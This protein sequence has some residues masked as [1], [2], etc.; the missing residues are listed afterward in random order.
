MK[1]LR[2]DNRLF[3]VL[4][5]LFSVCGAII[6]AQPSGGPYGPIEQT[7]V[8][9]RIAANVYYVSP[10]G[11]P[12]QNGKNLDKPT[13]IEQAFEQ[14][15]SGD[16]IILHGGTY[17]TGNLY[18]NQKVTIQ[19]FANEKPVL[20]GTYI[21][22]DWRKLREDIWVTKWEHLFDTV[23]AGWWQKHREGM[24]T[25]LHKF[26]NDM[27]FVNGK[28]MQSCG[29][30]GEVDE[31]HFYIDYEAGEV[32]IGTDPTDKLVEIT[33]FDIAL[34]R[35][36]DEY[37]GKK[38]DGKGPAIRGI[39]FTQYAYRAIEIEGYDP[40][41]VS[42]ESEHGKDVVGTTIENCE[43]SYCSRVGAYLRGDKLSIRQ[44]KIS[45][46]S[47]EG[48]FIL[49]SN[50]VLI[51]KNIFTQNNI[52]QITGYYPAAVKIFNQ[53]YRVTCNDNL[54]IDHP[55]SNGIWYDVGNVDGI[56]TNN[57]LENIGIPDRG[58]NKKS[59]WPGDNA[60]FFEIS[61]NAILAGNVFVNCEHGATVLNSCNV[62]MYNNTFV[63]STLCIG[64]D[65]RSAQGDHFGWHPASGPDVDE[66]I[67]HVI[68]NNLLTA[69]ADFHRPLVYV[70]Q[71]SSFCDKVVDNPVKQMDFN[72]YILETVNE[73]VPV[74]L[75]SP[76]KNDNCQVEI[77]SLAELQKIDSK[78][79]KN[80]QIKV[81][82][83]HSV[84]KSPEL[85]NFE[86]IN[87][88]PSTKGALLPD[89]VYKALSLPQ[90]Q[91]GVSGAYTGME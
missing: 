54:V 13:T 62:E 65:S 8:I 39:T 73:D 43:I 88:T 89:V 16:Y 18:L 27:V 77:N 50:D 7:Y 12:N 20:K 55:Y 78:Y 90:K 68:V 75:W 2:I 44:C 24:Y 70:W 59:L 9:P 42:D 46:T 72:K 33:V 79:D 40:E 32:Y 69:T 86:L 29:W 30:I 31:D 15:I 74:I 38:S 52:E 21:A 63:N 85:E 57:W 87:S 41:K 60:F 35:T 34:L 67:G 45:H 23:P 47:T 3:T 66:R 37:K 61:K 26:N 64:R 71:P 17:R 81:Q 10:D 91:I 1:F 83:L 51:E 19:P 6:Q 36:T 82:A 25:P 49:S 56:F 80:G 53:C 28:F 76:Y 11:D 4:V 14:V 5:I 58:F 84:F 48:L 22:N